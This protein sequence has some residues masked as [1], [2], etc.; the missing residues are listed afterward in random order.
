MS[1]MTLGS[2]SV[3]SWLITVP[4]VTIVRELHDIVHEWCLEQCLACGNTQIGAAAIT[5]IAS[6][7]SSLLHFTAL[8]H[9]VSLTQ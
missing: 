8:L 3:S 6:L 7:F 5:F 1:Y 2:A 9:N 4:P